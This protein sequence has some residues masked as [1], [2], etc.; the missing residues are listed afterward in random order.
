MNSSTLGASL[1]RIEIH[2]ELPWKQLV[3]IDLEM[4]GLHPDVDHI[5]EIATIVTDDQLNIVAQG[6][7][8]AIKQSKQRLDQ[9]DDC[10]L[11]HMVKVDLR[12]VA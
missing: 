10:A 5:L 9:M 3:W 2:H 1:L 12:S 7:V 8:L 4:T 6:P 11:R